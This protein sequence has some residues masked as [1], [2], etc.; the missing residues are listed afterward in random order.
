VFTVS[1]LEWIELSAAVGAAPAFSDA[2]SALTRGLAHVLKKPLALLSRDESGWHFEAEGFPADGPPRSWGLSADAI[3]RAEGVCVLRDAAGPAWTG[4]VIGDL[5]DREWVLMVPGESV[6]WENSAALEQVVDTIGTKLQLVATRDQEA[7]V[8]RLG[9]TIFAFSRRL[10]REQDADALHDLV[11]RTIARQGAARTAALAVYRPGDETLAIVATRGYPRAL[12]EHIRIAPGDGIIGRVF[13]TGRAELCETAPDA[14]STRRLRYRTNSYMVLPILAGKRSLAVVALTDRADGRAF[15]NRDFTSARMLAAT[16]ALAFSHGRVTEKLTDLARIATVDAV[17]G[18]FN[19]RDFE[20]R[21]EA[22]VQRTRRQ[23]QDLA[24]LM[25]D[26]DNFK[27]INDTWGHVEGDR[28]L[29]DVADL[30]RGGVRIFDIC[31]RFG[32]E[33]FVIVMPGASAAVAIHVAER[34]RRAI[35]QH[36]AHEPLPITVSIG[37]G[38]LGDHMGADDL[39]RAAD[40]AL[41]AAK[42]AGKNVVWIDDEGSGARQAE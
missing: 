29:R 30:L 14:E 32:G 28:A 37:V 31:A 35:E 12:V 33:E 42:S 7:Y 27:R 26:I 21:L 8:S 24:L 22:E 25:I 18:L 19:R 16:A 34:I 13:A 4:I 36:S 6:S 40:R 38:T 20:S 5:H 2:V 10:A 15:D 11:L 41:I 39:V 3:A 1:D 23:K 9:R 17:T